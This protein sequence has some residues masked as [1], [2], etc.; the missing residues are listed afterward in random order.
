MRVV[1]TGLLYF[2]FVFAVGFVLGPIQE[3]WAVPRFGRRAA[4][5][6]EAPF[7]SWQSFSVRG[8]RLVV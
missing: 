1:T 2:A 4:E 7:S 3:L 8:G 5:L 6:L